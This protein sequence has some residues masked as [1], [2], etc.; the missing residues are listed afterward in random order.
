LIN[1]IG[2]RLKEL[3]I[4]L[5]NVNIFTFKK[6]KKKEEPNQMLKEPKGK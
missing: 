2:K 4:D 1:N 6:S 3:N 5:V